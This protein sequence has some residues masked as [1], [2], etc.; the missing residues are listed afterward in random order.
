MVPDGFLSDYSAPAGGLNGRSAG[1]F[2]GAGQRNNGAC[3]AF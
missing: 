1:R 3:N 2:V